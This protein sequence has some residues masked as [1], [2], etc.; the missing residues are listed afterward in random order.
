MHR[1]GRRLVLVALLLAAVL[2]PGLAY[3]SQPVPAAASHGALGV[4][5]SPIDSLARLWAWVTNLLPGQGWE[6][7]PVHTR[8]DYG[9]R[10]RPSEGSALD[11][12]G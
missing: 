10:I 5:I 3:A 6:G 8:S 9:P 7:A 2:A 12:N 11:P 4:A 1:S